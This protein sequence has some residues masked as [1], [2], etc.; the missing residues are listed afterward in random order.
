MIATIEPLVAA[1][2]GYLLLGEALAPLQ[3]LGGA[4]IVLGVAALAR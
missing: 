3:W 4:L 1:L 2:L